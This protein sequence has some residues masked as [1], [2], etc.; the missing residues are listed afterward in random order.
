[1][2]RAGL[3][4]E[5]AQ[6]RI[7]VIDVHG[8]LVEGY[9]HDAYKL[10]LVQKQDSYCDWGLADDKP[11]TLMEVIMHAKPGILLGLS[12]VSGLF[13]E[14]I[15]KSM[16]ENHHRPIIFPLSNP[17]ANCE[18]TPKD[19]LAWTEGRAIIATGSPFADEEYNGKHYSIGQGNNAFIFPGIGLAAV[20]GECSHISDEMILESAFALADYIHTHCAELDLIYPQVMDLK[21]VSL[22]VATRVLAKALEDGSARRQDLCNLELEAYIRAYL[23]EAKYLPYKYKE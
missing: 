23:W 21:N 11:P 22:S 8:L 17:T 2:I 16:A 10:P 9:T 20:I 19:I 7:F 18:A 1:M 4:A 15:I 3:T 5:Q 13:N 6:R 12:G 14:E